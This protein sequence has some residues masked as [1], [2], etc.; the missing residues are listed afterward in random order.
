M[1]KFTIFSV[2]FALSITLV[3]AQTQK[4]EKLNLKSIESVV[5]SQG[6]KIDN[7]T[8]ALRVNRNEYFKSKA[9]GADS[10][11]LSYLQARQGMYGLDSNLNDVKKNKF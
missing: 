11:A 10:I 8:Q 4:I 7:E 9:K 1:K 6:R 5:D 2:L 3:N